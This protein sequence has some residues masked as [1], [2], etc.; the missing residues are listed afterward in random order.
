MEILAEFL[1]YR[2]A[3]LISNL[4]TSKL[5][6]TSICLCVCLYIPIQNIDT[7]GGVDVWLGSYRSVSLETPTYGNSMISHLEKCQ[8]CFPKYLH[9]F[10][11]LWAA[12]EGSRFSMFLAMLDISWPFDTSHPVATKWCLVVLFC[13]SL[14]TREFFTYL[15]AIFISF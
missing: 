14:T 5:G 1:A 12:D 13:I 2:L 7:E 6:W 3:R 9:H 4:P 15:W 11:S 10:T 8:T